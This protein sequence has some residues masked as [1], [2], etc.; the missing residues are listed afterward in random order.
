M[1]ILR[2]KKRHAVSVGRVRRSVFPLSLVFN[3]MEDVV[4]MTSE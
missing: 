3:G 1:I 4:S 2:G